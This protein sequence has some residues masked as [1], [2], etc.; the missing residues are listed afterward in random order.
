[1][2]DGGILGQVI[3][4]HSRV[5]P[6]VVVLLVEGEGNTGV[7]ADLGHTQTIGAVGG[8]EQLFVRTDDAGQH[9]LH[10]EGAASLHEHGGVVGGGHMG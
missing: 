5:G 8:D 6:L 2:G 4:H 7:A 10:P 9:R 1:M 3:G